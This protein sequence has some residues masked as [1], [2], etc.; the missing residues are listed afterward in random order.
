MSDLLIDRL[1]E[2][3]GEIGATRGTGLVRISTKRGLRAAFF[4]EGNL[5][6]V[7]SDDPSERLADFVT[8]EGRLDDPVSRA[9]VASLDQPNRSIVAQL[10]EAH[11]C[12]P[13]QLQ[14]WLA[15][16]AHMCFGRAFDDGEGTVKVMPKAK[17]QHPITISIP[18]VVL[19]LESVRRME[20]D[21]L[22]RE[23]VGPLG[24][25]VAPPDGHLDR[26]LQVP[27]NYQEG[28]IASQ[29]TARMKLEELIRVTGLP[30]DAA[31]RAILALRV[32]G[33]IPRA[34]EPQEL[35]DT[36]R[37]RRREEARA[38]AVEVDQE[39]AALLALGM[40][41]ATADDEQADRAGA[42]SMDELSGAAPRVE[43]P[44]AQ[45]ST[46]QYSGAQPARKAGES[47]KLRLLASAYV[48]MAEAEAAA[49]NYNRAVEYYETAVEQKPGDLTVLLPFAK[50][51][52]TFKKPQATAYAERLLKQACATNPTKVEPYV[53][54]V[55]LYR[56]TGRPAQAVEVLAEAE[57]IGPRHPQVQALLSDRPRG[58]GGL[59]SRLRGGA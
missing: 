27:V 50:Y 22:V 11:V 20:N 40:S 48:Q 17:A 59:F 32:A 57:R 42:L 53:E 4:E 33:I 58:A 25:E 29:L 30:E 43:A 24:W 46:P 47:G 21:S 10:L 35:T 18:A 41:R 9:L 36:G 56:A 19:A 5:V 31:V 28:T 7:A 2:V 44:A 16:Y 13:E 12:T 45:P 8:G 15:E 1:A 14:P 49:G 26:L 51:L 37:L 34:E 39:V 38:A 52:L 54:L 3:L 55:K 23:S 6:Y